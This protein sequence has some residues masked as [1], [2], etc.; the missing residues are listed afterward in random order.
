MTRWCRRSQICLL[1]F[2]LLLVAT[3]SGAQSL[4]L[5]GDAIQGGLMVGWAEPGSI[6]RL[7][8]HPLKLRD[9]GRLLFGFGRNAPPLAIVEVR[10]PDGREEA[11]RIEIT[12]RDYEVQKIDGLP[13]NMVT[14]SAEELERIRAENK[15]IAEGRGRDSDVAHF[16]SG[17]VWPLIGTVTGV[18]GTQRI[19][20]GEPRQPHFGIDIAAPEGVPVHAA[21]TG[22]VTLVHDDMFY[23][24]GTI[25]LDHGYGLTSL[26]SHLSA[27]D[28]AVGQ[29]IQKG[30]RIGAVGSS[31]RATGAHLDWR[32][33]LFTTR[34]DPALLVGPM[35]VAD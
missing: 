24:G 29:L 17:Y 23:T 18:Y 22:V 27:V 2:I 16:D 20:N 6:V 14:P 28:V 32:I 26:Y 21:A 11:R 19:L 31:G 1:G 34:L 10:Y 13:S 9:D 33:N 8:G 30:E 12:S 3:P 4:R 35:P 15:Q 25:M 7:D 5:E